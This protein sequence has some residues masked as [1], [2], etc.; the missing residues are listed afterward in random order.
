M[1]KRQQAQAA[2]HPFCNLGLRNLVLA[3]SSCCLLCLQDVLNA[4]VAHLGS[5]NV[6][7]ADVALD[8]L[9][10]L[11]KSQAGLLE[12]ADALATSMIDWLE[13]FDT[14]QLHKVSCQV[15]HAACAHI[16]FQPD[17]LAGLIWHHSASKG[18]LSS[19]ACSQSPAD[20]E[21]LGQNNRQRST[22][23]LLQATSRTR[24]IMLQ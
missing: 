1:P 9:S 19:S 6:S 7:E 23:Y 11:A 20:P 21:K 5:C 16:T 24:C 8:S 17:G 14:A 10:A 4:L 18:G 13:S 15:F 2:V 3:R 12:H 22:A